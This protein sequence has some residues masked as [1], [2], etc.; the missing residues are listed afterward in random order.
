MNLKTSS[1]V[2]LSFIRLLVHLCYCL[3]QA[4]CLE[5]KGFMKRPGHWLHE[6]HSLWG[7][8]L[9]ERR[10]VFCSCL[11][12]LTCSH[13]YDKPVVARK[14]KQFYIKSLCIPLYLNVGMPAP[15]PFFVLFLTDSFTV[16]QG[17]TLLSDAVII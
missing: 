16:D 1:E 9:G 5:F 10:L 3:Y 6:G 11:A 14:P 17:A 7:E 13:K 15:H 4:V 8:G 12:W 2:D